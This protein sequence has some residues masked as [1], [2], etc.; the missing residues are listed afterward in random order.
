MG[1]PGHRWSSVPPG[2]AAGSWSTCT[3]ISTVGQLLANQATVDLLGHWDTLMARGQPV[4]KYW[5]TVGQPVVK[6]WPTIGQPGPRWP[7]VPPGHAAASWST[8]T[9]ILAN[10][11][12]TCSQTLANQVTV[13]LLCH[14]GT[15]LARGQPV[16]KHW[17][18]V[19]Q[20]VVKHWPTIGQ[21]G[22]CWPSGPLGHTDGSWSACTQIL[23]NHWP[24][25]SQ[26]LANHWP[27]R[28]PLASC[29]TMARRWLVV[30][31]LASRPTETPSVPIPGLLHAEQRL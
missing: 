21:P 26:I 15:P 1:Q 16:L 14:Q 9:E 18:T 6:H 5:P 20:P 28:P 12:P 27:T 31:L 8:C 3:Q 7:P 17:P 13:G 22:H 4:L 30:A 23:A 19:G 11:W 10:C 24:T 25:C 2:H 29:A